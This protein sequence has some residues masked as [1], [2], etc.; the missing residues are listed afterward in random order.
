MRYVFGVIL[1]AAGLL[2]Q[3]APQSRRSLALSLISVVSLYRARGNGPAWSFGVP[4]DSLVWESV[5]Y[6]ESVT[7]DYGGIVDASGK[8]MDGKYWRYRG[9]FGSFCSYSKVDQATAAVLDCL[10]GKT[11]GR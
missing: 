11:P 7:S 2:A 3:S 8:T 5:E 9:M 6:S 4:S 10:M 1:L